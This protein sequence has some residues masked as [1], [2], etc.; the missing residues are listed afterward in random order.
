MSISRELPTFCSSTLKDIQE[1]LTD[2]EGRNLL[3]T[4]GDLMTSYSI[5]SEFLA[6]LLLIFYLFFNAVSNPDYTALNDRVF[7]KQ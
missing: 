5:S 6:T 2:D 3:L 4:V 7:S 1:Y